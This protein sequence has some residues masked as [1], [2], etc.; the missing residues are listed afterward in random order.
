DRRYCAVVP[1]RSARWAMP[2]PS[3][4]PGRLAPCTAP[5]VTPWF[6][7]PQ[8]VWNHDNIRSTTVVLEHYPPALA[9]IVHPA[10]VGLKPLQQGVIHGI[11]TTPAHDHD[12]QRRG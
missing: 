11:A 6:H 7:P 4:A 10:T 2:A 1:P 5:V 9:Q 8:G 12:P 3:P